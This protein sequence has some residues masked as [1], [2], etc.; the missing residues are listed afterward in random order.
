M[1]FGFAVVKK[2]YHIYRPETRQEAHY[3]GCWV[4]KAYNRK[5][6]LRSMLIIGEHVRAKCG[7]KEYP[8][9][10]TH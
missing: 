8:I 2:N 10:S 3:L 5:R 7:G 4:N 1:K 9:Q 6:M